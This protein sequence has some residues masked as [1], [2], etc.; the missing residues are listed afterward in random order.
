MCINSH[1]KYD[2]GVILSIVDKRSYSKS[3]IQY[4]V[5]LL[6]KF[7]VSNNVEMTRE[8]LKT[9]FGKNGIMRNLS[10]DRTI[11]ASRFAKI[12]Q[13]VTVK[14]RSM[15]VDSLMKV[16]NINLDEDEKIKKFVQRIGTLLKDD[17]DLQKLCKKALDAN[18]EI[19]TSAGIL[20][21]GAAGAIVTGVMTGGAGTA[22]VIGLIGHAVSG[23]IG[24]GLTVLDCH[25]KKETENRLNQ[26]YTEY[27]VIR[28]Y[29]KTQYKVYGQTLEEIG[30]FR[31]YV[32]ERFQGYLAHHKKDKTKWNNAKEEDSKDA[33]INDI[34][35]EYE[36]KKMN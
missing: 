36:Q 10:G 3:N 31:D 35:Q 33:D 5:S 4:A 29:L 20:T 2:G 32:A 26:I 15:K 1:K 25:V 16:A 9:F 8:N 12:S 14:Y 17:E 24:G 22:A 27:T 30:K 13:A 6:N 11:G 34:L 28:R 7:K 21:L 18:K 23:L 19:A